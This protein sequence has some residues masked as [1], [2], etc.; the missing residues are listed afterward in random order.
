MANFLIERTQHSSWV[1]VFKALVTVHH[2]MCYG[3]ERFLQ[4][5]ASS[6]CTFQLSNFTDKSGAQGYDMSTFIRRYSKYLN[7]KAV[8]Y[9]SV[10]FDFCKV[11]RGKEDGT[12]RTMN[13][14]KL[15]KTV[16]ALQNQLDALLEF[17]CTS[18]DLI[19]PVIKSCFMLLFRDLIR[20][21]ACYNDGIINLLE[22][23]FDMNKKHCREALDIYKKF[24]IRMDRVAEFLKVAE[25]IGIDKGD[26]PDLTKAPSSLL[27][28][29]EQ[30]LA[31]LEGKKATSAGETRLNTYLQNAVFALSST[32]TAFGTVGGSES[33]EVNGFK[34][35][36]YLR[37]IAEEGAAALKHDSPFMWEQPSWTDLD[38]KDSDTTGNWRNTQNGAL[39][40]LSSKT[41]P[42]LASPA[43]D[44]LP[45][46]SDHEKIVDLFSLSITEGHVSESNLE[47]ASDDLLGLSV[48]PF[49]DSLMNNNESQQ[50]SLFAPF[51]T[52]GVL[53][54]TTAP[55]A[56]IDL[57]ATDD[58]FAAVFGNASSIV[59]APA[60]T[61]ITTTSPEHS[62]K[63]GGL[64]LPVADIYGRSASPSPTAELMKGA[65]TTPILSHP[66]EPAFGEQVDHLEECAAP[67]ADMSADMVWGDS[68][69]PSGPSPAPDVNP[70][71]SS[72]EPSSSL[73]ATMA[74]TKVPYRSEQKADLFSM[75][76]AD[77][78]FGETTSQP[79]P[80][81]DTTP[82]TTPA[83]TAPPPS[84]FGSWDIPSSTGGGV[85]NL[86]LHS[87]PPL[88]AVP[89]TSSLFQESSKSSALDDLNFTIQKVMNKPS[90][91]PPSSTP[92]LSSPFFGGSRPSAQSASPVGASPV[93]GSPL[94]S[95]MP[96]L[97]SPGLVGAHAS[98][99][100]P[101]GLSSPAKSVTGGGS[102][103]SGFDL[104]GDVL[105]PQPVAG[106]AK[107]PQSTVPD[108]KRTQPPSKG[109]VKG[110]L[111]SSLAS[112]AQN[113]DISGPGKQQKF[114]GH[115]WGSPK[116]SSKTSVASTVTGGG[117]GWAGPSS[118]ISANTGW[119]SPQH[120][121]QPM[122]SAGQFGS[123]G[124]GMMGNSFPQQPK[125]GIPQ[126][127]F[128]IGGV[129]RPPMVSPGMG[130][131]TG[132]SMSMG[133][134]VT[135][136]QQP[137]GM[138][139]GIQPQRPVGSLQSSSKPPSSDTI[140]LFGAL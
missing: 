98:P 7:E 83:P 68:T 43:T 16:P 37:K 123:G 94:S 24:L 105:Q 97:D 57:F 129:M 114:G 82:T 87:Q 66:P 35:D 14:E 28:S 85:S 17:D 3:N 92:G 55:S 135:Q 106:G 39:P 52:N 11:K 117:G 38:W 91:A 31:T 88:H 133:M 104:F 101:S 53:A 134:G 131:G 33:Q 138:F 12:L 140:D 112:L 46:A 136:P 130:M 72:F 121:Y 70:F 115:Q 122:G 125:S 10:A 108:T 41:N 8:A 22:K 103:A 34:P 89:V 96:R 81:M 65:G 4:Y 69:K 86:D 49:A 47:K 23:Y 127:N 5:F 29:L 78:G 84:P 59:A 61:N 45:A 100:P 128:G 51:G 58:S 73:P 110:D 102:V 30:H 62:T 71:G 63:G 77:F 27:D 25:N 126:Q 36:D 18:S 13:A 48:N 64:M 1:V 54:S 21:F 137:V 26:I 42:F 2:L 9:R 111:D 113:L 60:S 15:L 44:T 118:G 116:P 124:T 40:N 19:N 56:S 139:G 93:I 74:A 119:G 67:E 76:D 79:P 99:T 109:I 75:D 132:M 95:S 90:A 120:S 6:N 32:S 20:L 80:I 50:S 107:I